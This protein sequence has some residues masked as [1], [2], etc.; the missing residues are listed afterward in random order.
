LPTQPFQRAFAA[1]D[2]FQLDETS[3]FR[4]G[5]PETAKL[6]SGSNSSG[7]NTLPQSSCSEIASVSLAEQSVTAV[8]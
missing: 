4:T 6:R 8:D 1:N 5:D 2:G 7:L 3:V